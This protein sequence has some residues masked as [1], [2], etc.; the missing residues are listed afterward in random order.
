MTPAIAAPACSSGRALVA[1]RRGAL[2]AVQMKQTAE[3]K[4][5][6]EIDGT[7]L[8]ALRGAGFRVQLVDSEQVRCVRA[9]SL[10]RRDGRDILILPHEVL[11]RSRGMRCCCGR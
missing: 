1:E 7:V 8:E 4:D 9:A 11:T 2:A 6:L 10:I 5:V 3:E